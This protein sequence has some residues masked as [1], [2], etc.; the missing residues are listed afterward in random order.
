M[1]TVLLKITFLYTK[2][3]TDFDF[4]TFKGLK[5]I[6]T[7]KKGKE[8]FTSSTSETL[9]QG[10]IFI[11]TV[12]INR[13]YIIRGVARIFQRGWGGGRGGGGAKLCRREGTHQIVMSFYTT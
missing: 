8:K 2:W 13:A 11:N 12:F 6:L 10:E 4:T 7:M 1:K 5:I 9:E 3:A